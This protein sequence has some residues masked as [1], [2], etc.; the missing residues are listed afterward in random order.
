[1][2]I[3]LVLVTCTAVILIA[4]GKNKFETTPKLEIKSIS[5]DEIHPGE[6]L[7]V[8]LQYFD[9]QGDLS[10]GAFTYI[11]VRTNTI[12]IPNPTANDKVDTIFTILP[13]FP[14]KSQAEIVQTISYNFM[15]ENPDPLSL[16][17]ND[18]MYFKFVVTDKEGNTSDTISTKVVTAVQP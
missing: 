9:K 14:D 17:K 8:V 10:K 6:S 18:S 7:R 15:D 16:G 1:M 4:C 11:R 12:P 5:A 3:L 2:R 13:E